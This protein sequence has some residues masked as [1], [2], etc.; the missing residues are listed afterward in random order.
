[1]FQQVVQ[2]SVCGMHLLGAAFWQSYANIIKLLLA[3]VWGQ[4]TND[5]YQGHWTDM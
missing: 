5:Y 3:C 4:E 1:M 2:K